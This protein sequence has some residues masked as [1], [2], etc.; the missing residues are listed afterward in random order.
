MKETNK[1]KASCDLDVAQDDWD[2]IVCRCEEVTKGEIIKAINDGATTIE[3]IKRKTRAGM[4]L[5]QSKTC[6]RA[7]QR[8]LAE[9]S[10]QPVAAVLPYTSRPPVRPISIG[11]LSSLMEEEDD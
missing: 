2:Q 7:I 1:D 8:I 4:G 11:I 3:E 6:F 10:G 9:V 5:C